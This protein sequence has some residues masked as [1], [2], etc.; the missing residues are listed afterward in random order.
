MEN[1]AKL[2]KKTQEKIGCLGPTVLIFTCL[3][4]F[5]VSLIQQSMAKIMARIVM[6]I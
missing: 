1:I 4:A 6:K 2:S 3:F 5:L